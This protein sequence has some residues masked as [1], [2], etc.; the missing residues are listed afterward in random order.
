MAT[1][2]YMDAEYPMWVAK[3]QL[4]GSCDIGRTTI[5]GDSR[6]MAGLLPNRVDDG[7]V[8]LALGGASPIEVAYLV[9][10]LLSCPVLPERVVI[11]FATEHFLGTDTYW[12]RS[13]AFGFLDVRQAEEVRSVSKQLGDDSIYATTWHGDITGRLK[14][15]AYA[16]KFP[17][18]YFGSV[19]AGGFL[20]REPSN[21][22][23]LKRVTQA[24]GHHF[25]GTAAG[26]SR[27]SPEDVKI[28]SFRPRPIFDF[29]FER[30]V[31]RLG[32][33]GV[34]V[35]YVGM[36]VNESTYRAMR[37]EVAAQISAYLEGYRLR[38]PNFHV[39]GEP[40]PF[41]PDEY[42]GDVEHLNQRGAERWSKYLSTQLRS[43]AH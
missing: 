34:P 9:D 14:N 26:T 38:H 20:L 40:V 1:M 6:P 39:I 41:L 8:N 33:K 27:I 10:D 23:I 15:Y 19:L 32:A 30:A 43:A 25:F 24:R 22:E 28:E 13:L 17:S 7:A 3:L 4:L 2:K 21:E 5:V 37:P 12:A 29:Y 16:V 18:L 42:F 11:S 35:Y 31:A 36:P